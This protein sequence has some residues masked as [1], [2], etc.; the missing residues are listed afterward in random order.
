MLGTRPVLKPPFQTYDH[1]ISLPTLQALSLADATDFSTLGCR[2]FTPLNAG[3][4]GPE[5]LQLVSAQRRF[6]LFK[7]LSALDRVNPTYSDIQC[8]YNTE[9]LTEY[10][11]LD[12]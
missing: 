4:I 3:T 11:L 1:T 12:M 6:M 10:H 7:Q 2:F 9:M 8:V 5:L